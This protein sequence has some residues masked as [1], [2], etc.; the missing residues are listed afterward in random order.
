MIPN[1]VGFGI[2][3]LVGVVLVA[4]VAT[5]VLM[6]CGSGLSWIA[7]SAFGRSLGRFTQWIV[8]G[9]RNAGTTAWH[10]LTAA[11]MFSLRSLERCA[12]SI[13]GVLFIGLA[14]LALAAPYYQNKVGLSTIAGIAIGGAVI[15]GIPLAFF[16]PT[17]GKLWRSLHFTMP[18]GALSG[19]VFV[20]IA[21]ILAS[22]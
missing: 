15:F 17:K 14:I 11:G 10:G 21:F 6:A 18:W 7:E 19:L 12:P 9:V 4:A 22:D 8:R 2:V 5:L 3:L 13:I 1:N 20:S 16:L